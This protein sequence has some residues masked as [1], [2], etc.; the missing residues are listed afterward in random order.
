M[1]TKK[2]RPADRSN[3]PSERSANTG[4]KRLTNTSREINRNEEQTT[5]SARQSGS[6]QGR[7]RSA[8]LDRSSGRQTPTTERP[9]LRNQD[10]STRSLTT[11]SNVPGSEIR[12]R[13]PNTEPWKQT[14]GDEYPTQRKSSPQME[15]KADHPEMHQGP[16]RQRG[17]SERTGQQYS[18]TG[19]SSQIM[20]KN[21]RAG[22]PANDRGNTQKPE[23]KS[24]SKSANQ[25]MKQ[26]GAE[27][28]HHRNAPQQR[29]DEQLIEE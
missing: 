18:V 1:S 13:K 12:D 27:Q 4:N 17:N 5:P 28:K 29:D 26:Q 16:E 14:S 10:S 9:E 3:Q 24:R 6:D 19:N 25:G 8:D 7:Q 21:L 20:D 23:R 15:D 2:N 11:G 22:H